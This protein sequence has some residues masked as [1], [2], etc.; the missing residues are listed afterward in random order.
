MERKRLNLTRSVDVLVATIA[1]RRSLTVLHY[2]SDFELVSAATGQP[3]LWIVAAG[4]AD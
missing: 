1:E 2:D 3:N 4:T